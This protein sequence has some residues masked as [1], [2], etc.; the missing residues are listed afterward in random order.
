MIKKILPLFVLLFT[1]TLANAQFKVKDL[2]NKAKKEVNKIKD[3]GNPL[4]Q[5]EIGKGLKE[6][7]NNGVGEA[8]DFLSKEGGYKNSIY[9]ITMPPEAQK[10]TKK[11][12]NVPGFNNVE[13]NLIAKMNEAA[14]IAA[15]KAKPIFVNAIKQ[16][17]FKD[18]MNILMGEDNAAT[19]YLKSTTYKSLYAE[20]MPV[21]QSALDEVNAREYWRG[22]V[23]AY[24]KIPFVDKANPELDDHVNRSA[25]DG[26][27]K[28]IQKKEEGIRNDVGMRNT[29]LLKKV[30]AKQD[31]KND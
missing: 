17:S 22:A 4:S 29:D 30:F 9:K 10:V 24:N 26:M 28:L 16:M 23:K 3:G 2:A 11:L 1:F 12:K 21:I 18:A 19:A 25:L 14:E 5:D 20:F 13:A 8:V 15:K 27:F 31:K 6:A 7:L